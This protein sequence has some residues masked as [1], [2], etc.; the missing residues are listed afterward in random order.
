L[1]YIDLIIAVVLLISLFSGFRR[2]LVM[3]VFSLLA[4]LAALLGAFSFM[5]FGA[6]R[7][8]EYIPELDGLLPVFSF[9]LLFLATYILLIITGKIFSKVIRLSPLGLFDQLG[10]SLFGAAKGVLFLSLI[11]WMINGFNPEFMDESTSDSRLYK[12][13]SVSGNAIVIYGQEVF[14][15]LK[16]FISNYDLPV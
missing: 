7:L 4:L 15:V 1:N 3:E 9:I 8:G 16:N 2:G 11:V 14:P 5:N 6:E 13:L 12:Y 10:G